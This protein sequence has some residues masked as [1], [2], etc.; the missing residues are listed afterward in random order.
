MSALD[1]A[2]SRAAQHTRVLIDSSSRDFGRSCETGRS[3]LQSPTER[4]VDAPSQRVANLEAKRDSKRYVA[5]DSTARP[6][7]C[8]R[9]GGRRRCGT[10]RGRRRRRCAR[11]RMGGRGSRR[12]GRR[13]VT[14]THR[15]ILVCGWMRSGFGLRRF[16]RSRWCLGPRRGS[17]RFGQRCRGRG[18]GVHGFG[19]RFVFRRRTLVALARAH[20]EERGAQPQDSRESEQQGYLGRAAQLRTVEIVVIG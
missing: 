7:R 16:A 12:R 10:R 17:R 6:T 4:R 8:R 18:S 9:F 3:A 20:D 2:S 13:V 19:S 11:S 15:G 1:A 5:H 14:F